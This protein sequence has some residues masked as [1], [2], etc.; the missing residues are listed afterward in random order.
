MPFLRR[1]RRRPVF[2]VNRDG[3]R[4]AFARCCKDPARFRERR[5]ASPRTRP[6]WYRH[7]VRDGGSA[8][9]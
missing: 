8:D 7:C 3:R 5:R 4:R 9:L 2:G 1:P 6:G